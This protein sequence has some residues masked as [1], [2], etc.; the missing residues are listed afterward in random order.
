M[1][2]EMTDVWMDPLIND[3]P[4]F[5]INDPYNYVNS[6]YPSLASFTENDDSVWRGFCDIH[7]DY[8]NSNNA[9]NSAH[10]S[11]QLNCDDGSSAPSFSSP[12]ACTSK[13]YSS[14]YSHETLSSSS[15]SSNDDEDYDDVPRAFMAAPPHM[16]T[17]RKQPPITVFG[18]TN[19]PSIKKYVKTTP[20]LRPAKSLAVL[21]KKEKRIRRLPAK[22]AM[23]V[24]KTTLR[25]RHKCSEKKTNKQ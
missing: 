4:A 9:I 6:A 25:Q 15:S 16:P 13:Y 12:T 7:D 24:V 21:M 22:F 19:T 10:D 17:V 8:Y 1:F 5:M 18:L 3:S 11:L 14:L 20:S 2:Y 23:Y